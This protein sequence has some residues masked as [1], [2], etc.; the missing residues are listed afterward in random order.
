[1]C[2]RVCVCLFRHSVTVITTNQMRTTKCVHAYNIVCMS[3]QYSV[4]VRT[5]ATLVAQTSACIECT[6]THRRRSVVVVSVVVVVV[7]VVVFIV[8]R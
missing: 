1:V 8:I 5:E 7:A 2:V 3:V 6:H 4:C